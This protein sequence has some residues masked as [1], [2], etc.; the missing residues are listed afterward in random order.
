MEKR[1]Q[2]SFDTLEYSYANDN[3]TIAEYLISISKNNEIV[4]LGHLLNPL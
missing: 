4:W 1:S 2:L 3:L